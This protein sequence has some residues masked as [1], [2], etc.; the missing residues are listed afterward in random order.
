MHYHQ[1]P[2]MSWAEVDACARDVLQRVAPHCLLSTTPVPVLDIFERGLDLFDVGYGVEE[3]PFGV[4]AQFDPRTSEIILAESVYLD[5]HRGHCRARFTVAHEIGHAVMHGAYYKEIITGNRKTKPLARGQI[6]A[7]SDPEKQAN[8]FAA[9]FLMPT[10]LVAQ[11]VQN[12]YGPHM[13]SEA[14]AVSLSAAEIK[15]R[16]L[17][18]I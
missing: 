4:E 15:I 6:P 14:F 10:P 12:G 11:L 17:I 9:E 2:G 7:Y 18:K 1:V 16:S 8:R 13:I 5:L 3:L